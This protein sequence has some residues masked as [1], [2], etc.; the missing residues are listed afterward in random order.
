MLQTNEGTSD[1]PS[2]K[3]DFTLALYVYKDRQDIAM[4][5]G[6]VIPVPKRGADYDLDRLLAEL[7]SIKKSYPGKRDILILAQDKVLYKELI[8]S[9]DTAIGADFPNITVSGML[10]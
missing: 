6:R 5:E 8:S 3:N 4:G 9:M 7:L 1:T 2:M 10:E